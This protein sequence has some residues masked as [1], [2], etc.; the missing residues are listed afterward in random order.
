MDF[1]N[2]IH[3]IQ[4]SRTVQFTSLIQQLRKEGRDIID[5]AVGE[6]HFETPAKIIDA[7]RDAL[8]AGRTRYGPVSG[9]PELRARLAARLPG[10]DAENI[11]VC[12]GAK[13]ALYVIFQTLL[14]PGNEVIIPSPYWVSFPEQ[15]KLAGGVPVF[16]PT[17]NHQPCGQDIQ[18]AVTPKTKAIL[19]NSP[20]NPTGA[21]YSQE[22]FE[23]LT[24]LAC[25]RNLTVIADEAYREFVYDGPAPEG[26]E[27][28]QAARQ[29]TILVRSF[30]KD[31]SMTG[32]RLGFLAA[33]GEFVKA[34]TALQGHISGNV[35][36]FAQWGGLAALDLASDIPACWH[37]ELQQ[38]RDTAFAYAASLFSCVKPRGA[39]YLFPEIR[40]HLKPGE[41]A[42][43]FAGRLL[44]RAGVAVVP[45]EAFGASG[46]IRISYAV[47]PQRLTEGFERIAS[48]L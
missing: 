45:G 9:M 37:R 15:V 24:D 29:R 33:P 39:F 41:T 27:A 10:Y 13:Q 31:W 4:P 36:T 28:I 7:T 32:F 48:V 21:V 46:H 26:M 47:A 1:S 12:N 18:E 14:N 6:P 34:A 43:D 11:L 44:S 35:C 23:F 42:E 5:F 8:A 17:R 22:F 19:V 16:V 3:N 25:R 2:R 40:Q 30:S 38:N 20:H